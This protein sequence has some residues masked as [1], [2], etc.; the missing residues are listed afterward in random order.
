QVS[1][2]FAG[3]KGFLDELPVNVLADYEQEMYTY[4]EANEPSIFEELKEQ[5]AISSSLE[6]KMKKTLTS[7]GETFKATK[8]LN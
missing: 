3:T 6:E 8:G 5:Q 7:F 1:I 2:L 4:I